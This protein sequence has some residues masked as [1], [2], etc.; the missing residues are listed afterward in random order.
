[1]VSLA[2][3]RQRHA[4]YKTDPDLQD[5]HA[6]Y[7][8]II[9][10]DDHEV[11]NDQWR[12]GAENHNAR[13]ARATTGRAGP[14]RTARTTSGCRSAWTAPPGCATA[15]G[16]TAGCGSAGS[17]RSACSTC[18]PTAASRSRPRRRRR[19]RRRGRGRATR[20]HHH[21]HASSCG[22]LK[23]SLDRDRRAVEGDRQPGDDRAGRPSRGVPDALLEPD[24]RRDRAAARGRPALQRRPVGRLHRRPHAR[25]SST[26]ATTRSR[27]RCSSPA[28]STP[29]GPSELPYDAG[30]LPGRR[31]GRRRVRLHLGDVEQPQG[32]HRHAAAHRRAWRSRRRSWPTTGT[33]STSTSTTTAS[34][35]STSPA[36]RAQMDW[37]VIGDR[38]D[39]NTPITWTRSLATTDRHRPAARGRRAG[40]RLMCERHAPAADG[41]SPHGLAEIAP[42]GARVLGAAGAGAALDRRARRRR[43]AD[44]GKPRFPKRR[45]YVLVVDG[46]RPDEIDQGLTPNLLALRD[47]GLRFPRAVVDAGDGDHPQPRDD[48]DRRPPRP[49][50]RAGQRDLRPHGSATSATSTGRATSRS[51]PSSS[52][53]TGAGYRT[54]TVLSKEYLYGVFGEPGDRTAGSRCRSSRSP[55][56]RPTCSRC[57]PR[58]RCSTTSTRT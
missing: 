5:L 8:W 54:G 4:Q 58:W 42:D 41:R 1:M 43:A 20:P 3:Y 6:T 18:A 55:A 13:H 38:A 44:S 24:Q 34:R 46:C 39:Q 19:C 7:P 11:T 28:T 16:S 49:H 35:S 21:R 14:A 33:S 32:H 57:R 15:T 25:C 9:T 2:D 56:T 51:R 53:S 12:D 23:E 52:G 29:A 37:F 47:G 17:P 36:K 30:D 45:A 27:T 48:D 50:R 22:W 10:W 40:G 31:L 26:S